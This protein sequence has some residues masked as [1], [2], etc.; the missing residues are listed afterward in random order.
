MPSFVVILLYVVITIYRIVEEY[1]SKQR[2]LKKP[3]PIT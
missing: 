1:E 2:E 3:E